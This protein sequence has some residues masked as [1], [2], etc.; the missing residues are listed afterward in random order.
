MCNDTGADLHRWGRS[1]PV[2]RLLVPSNR[3]LQTLLRLCIKPTCQL[4]FCHIPHCKDP[5]RGA[6]ECIRHW[7]YAVQ[8]VIDCL[9]VCCIAVRRN[10]GQEGTAEVEVDVGVISSGAGSNPRHVEQKL[11]VKVSV[12]DLAELGGCGGDLV[13]LVQLLGA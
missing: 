5:R 12:Y 1:P 7:G 6:D 4:W 13:I 9:K 2:F 3:G 11:K 10:I 8:L